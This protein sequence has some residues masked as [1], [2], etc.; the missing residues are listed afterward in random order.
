MVSADVVP[1]AKD[2]VSASAPLSVPH[3]NNPAPTMSDR[4]NH[5]SSD[6]PPAQ[7]AADFASLNSSA[8]PFL[9]AYRSHAPLSATPA[10]T[11]WHKV[12]RANPVQLMAGE[13]A[14][15]GTAP[16]W[17]RISSTSSRF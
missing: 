8:V 2:F 7:T 1:S 16:I 10:I 9:A 12:T 14:A 17:L 3:R 5:E 6:R 11:N 4:P 13:F 15:R